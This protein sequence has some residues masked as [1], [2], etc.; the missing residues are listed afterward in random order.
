M[1]QN[2][3]FCC[4]K[5]PNLGHFVQ[6]SGLIISDSS[7]SASRGDKLSY[8][9]WVQIWLLRSFSCFSIRYTS[10][11]CSVITFTENL[12]TF[13]NL[14]GTALVIFEFIFRHFRSYYVNSP[15]GRN[16]SWHSFMLYCTKLWLLGANLRCFSCFWQRYG[17]LFSSRKQHDFVL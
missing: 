6:L 14:T 9:F 1:T 10:V 16:N 3:Y 13:F 5:S 15:F 17:N 7:F 11:G 2:A 8:G 4:L 12:K